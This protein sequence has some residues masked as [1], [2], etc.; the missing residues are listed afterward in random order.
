MTEKKKFNFCVT[1]NATPKQIYPYMKLL[2]ETKNHILF[3][4][5]VVAISYNASYVFII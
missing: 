4:T 2:P 1:I 5:Q 3:Y